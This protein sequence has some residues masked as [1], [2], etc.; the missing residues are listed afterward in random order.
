MKI[1]QHCRNLMCNI[2]S[3]NFGT[4]SNLQ[5]IMKLTRLRVVD[6]SAL[7]KQAM[8]EGRPPRCIHVY[9]KT[10][11]GTIGDKIL[12]TIKGLKKKAVIVGVKK[13]QK[14]FIPKF[15]TNNI[16]L[17]DDSGNP[18]GSR[19]LVPVP[20]VLRKRPEFAKIMALARF[21]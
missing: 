2:G 19:I 1:L 7:G 6:N 15:D 20:A 5:H 14:A 17:V 13:H 4:S 16:I 10:G 9:N 11:I 12:V 21:V 3:K 8:I 18:L